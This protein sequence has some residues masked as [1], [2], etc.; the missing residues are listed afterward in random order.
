MSH[1]TCCT[2]TPE[3]L[4]GGLSFRIMANY[5][6]NSSRNSASINRV[7]FNFTNPAKLVLVVVWCPQ[8]Y[9]YI[10]VSTEVRFV[11]IKFEIV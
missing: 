10:F 6:Y 2:I 5:F 11:K 9:F 1:E 3:V 4:T 7:T 8:I